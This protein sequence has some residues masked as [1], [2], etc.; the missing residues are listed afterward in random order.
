MTESTAI[1]APRLLT[2]REAAD[3]LGIATETAY[4]L[5]RRKE[6]PSLKVGGSVRV[7]PVELEQWLDERRSAA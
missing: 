2:I 5:A 3:R 1:H 6:L 7:D 4:V